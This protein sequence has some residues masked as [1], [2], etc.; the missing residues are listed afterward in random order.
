MRQLAFPRPLPQFPLRCLLLQ[1]YAPSSV[2]T[3]SLKSLS[4]PSSLILSA[5]LHD[6]GEGSEEPVDSRRPAA[7]YRGGQTFHEQ[8]DRQKGLLL[9]KARGTREAPETTEG[10]HCLNEN[11]ECALLPLVL[12][13]ESRRC[14]NV[15]PSRAKCFEKRSKKQE[16]SQIHPGAFRF[17]ST[18]L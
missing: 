5:G 14:G 11:L 4:S 10:G 9:T 18:P 16:R 1:Y 17:L 3:L 13:K 8:Q 15:A 6:G 2:P 12:E 7:G